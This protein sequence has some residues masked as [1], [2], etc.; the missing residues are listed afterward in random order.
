MKYRRVFYVKNTGEV[1]CLI[2]FKNQIQML[3]TFPQLSIS[4]IQGILFAKGF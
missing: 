2:C 3:N 4:Y 1:G